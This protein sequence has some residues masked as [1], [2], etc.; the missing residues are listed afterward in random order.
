MR[1]ILFVVFL[2]LLILPVFAQECKYQRTIY[3]NEFDYICCCTYEKDQINWQQIS[4]K[5]RNPDTGTPPIS[6]PT[7]INI[8]MCHIQLD[9][10]SGIIF[11]DNDVWI[12]KGSGDCSQSQS[13][14]LHGK[15]WKCTNEKSWQV[16]VGSNPEYDILPGEYIYIWKNENAV[17]SSGYTKEYN[18]KRSGRA[19]SCQGLDVAG[20]VGCNFNPSPSDRLYNENIDSRLNGEQRLN[21]N[22][23][24]RITGSGDRRECGNTCETC[25]S[26][27]DCSSL[28]PQKVNYNGRNLGGYCSN[29]ELVLYGCQSTGGSVCTYFDDLNENGIKD[30]NEECF[31]TQE[32][33]K[34]DIVRRITTGI[35]C[36]GS[37][38]CRGVGDYYCEW[39]SD[40][41]SR[42][43][44]KAQCEKDTDCGTTTTC[45]NSKKIIKEPYCS[46]QKQCEER[47]IKT[48]IEC[49]T[50]SDCDS[51]KYC[52]SDYK[53]ELVPEA[54][55]T[56]TVG[57]ETAAGI[58]T[59]DITGQATVSPDETNFVLIIVAIVTVI[60][61]GLGGYMYYTKRI[62]SPKTSPPKVS[63]MKNYCTKCGTSNSKGTKFCTSCGEGLQK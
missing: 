12:F 20:S 24:F 29:G 28:H 53:C 30:S 7:G 15:R 51:G 31:E 48:N 57:R 44:L 13:D 62:G 52:T 37:D 55:T 45:D 6:C 46:S 23:C 61:G 25:S 22:Q 60:L 42:C 11:G 19:G 41:T 38:D 36:C 33:N 10:T 59:R 8:Q 9:V 21:E 35:E 39:T 27:L 34:C 26:D 16:T 2:P 58:G 4:L 32:K 47:A 43:V 50:T 1:I 40:T 3:C 17:I 18:L 56:T 14:L 63:S 54:T 5:V 49:C